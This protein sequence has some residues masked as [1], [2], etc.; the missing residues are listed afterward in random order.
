[1]KKYRQRIPFIKGIH[2]LVIVHDN[3]LEHYYKVNKNK[4]SG[5][6]KIIL[7]ERVAGYLAQWN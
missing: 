6:H 5:F 3:Y 1:M 2:P 4:L 7:T